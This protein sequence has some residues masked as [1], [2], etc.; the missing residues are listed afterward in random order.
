[1]SKYL[2]FDTK[3]IYNVDAG[4]SY[5]YRKKREIVISEAP[6]LQVLY[7][8]TIQNIQYFVQVYF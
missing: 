3:V 8:D 7:Q 5:D 4:L 6:S 2:Y 1:M